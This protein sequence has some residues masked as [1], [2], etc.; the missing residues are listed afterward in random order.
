MLKSNIVSSSTVVVR[1]EA[2]ER[3]GV[4]DE[5]KEL[6]TAEDFDLWLRIVRQYE[7]AYVPYVGNY[8][9]SS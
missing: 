1:K 2:L 5:A 8:Y 6:V 4:F 3:A 9:R 7:H